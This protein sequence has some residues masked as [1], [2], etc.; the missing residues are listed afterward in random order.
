MQ[1]GWEHILTSI[2]NWLTDWKCRVAINGTFFQMEVSDLWMLQHSVLGPQLISNISMIW[3]R[4]LN[5]PS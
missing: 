1:M 4:E 3:M 2:E 5:I